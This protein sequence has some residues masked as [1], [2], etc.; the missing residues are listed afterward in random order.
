[1]HK[2]F[3]CQRTVHEVAFRATPKSYFSITYW[4]N[5]FLV[6][7]DFTNSFICCMRHAKKNIL[8]AHLSCR[9]KH[10]ETGNSSLYFFKEHKKLSQNG[11][12]KLW[13]RNQFFLGCFPF[14]LCDLTTSFC[15]RC[16]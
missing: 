7:K 4:I 2:T 9:G 10:G 1:M 15:V 8:S 6:C 13:R 11:R 5:L 14:K 16:R 3:L 12:K